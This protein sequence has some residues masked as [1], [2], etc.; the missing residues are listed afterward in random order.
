MPA[1][2]PLL[3]ALSPQYLRQYVACPVAVEGT[4]VT[5]ACADPTD[6]VLVDDLR[7]FLGQRRPA[8][9]GA[10]R[11]HPRGHR[12]RTY[13]GG[14]ALQKIVDGIGPADPAG[15]AAVEAAPD[16]VT[17]LRDM[18]FEAP[19]VR[20]VNLLIE[21]A[22]GADASDIHV[23]P[24]E[25]TLRV[26]YRIDGH[27][28]RPG[29]AAATAP[30]RAHL[31]HQDHGRDEHRRAAP[32][33]GRPHP[34]HR[35]GA[36][37]G[38]PRLDRA[39]HPR[40]VDR[41]AA[42]GPIVRVPALRPARARPRARGGPSSASSAGLTASCSS[43]APPARGKTTT[44]YAALD[45]INAPERKIITVEDPVE[46]QLKGVNQIP[47]HPRHRAHVRERPPPHRA[48]GPGRHHRGRDPRPARR[49]RSPSRPRSP[50]TSSSRPCTPMMPPAR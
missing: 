16:D 17:L 47:V 45:K 31:A 29:G 48:P 14:T 3:K 24:F 23:E 26:R 7:L 44:L 8:V 30:G 33:P 49:R 9:P 40:R 42:P 13:E 21:E 32:A 4:T 5:V 34:S 41:D 25:D 15:E 36:P 12:A 28:V 20:L 18:A 10:G 38:H 22:V 39:D 46:Y 6:P 43:P 50:A 1:T 2:A 11:G 37:G 27:P 19:V 35:A